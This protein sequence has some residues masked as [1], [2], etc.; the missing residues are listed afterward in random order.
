MLDMKESKSIFLLFVIILF[1][2]AP[3]SGTSQTVFSVKDRGHRKQSKIL[4]QV[5]RAS[6]LVHTSVIPVVDKIREVQE[7]TAKALTL[8]NGV[9]RNMKMVR[10]LIEIEGEIAELVEK[11]IAKLNEPRD[12]D[13]DGEDDLAFLDKWKHVKILLAILGQADNVFDLFKNV[14]EQD[15]TVMDDRGRLTLI[16]DAYH[17]ALKIRR[18]I[19]V[20]IRRINREIAGH[21]REK[22]EADM[23]A[24][25]FGAT[26]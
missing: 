3:F 16:K 24:K 10:R 1:F 13:G 2:I 14:V 20:Q 25:L 11:S 8:V 4:M 19:R 23:F 7:F 5:E 18:C 6:T 9:I 26:E 21:R 12:T 15:A 17:D 22:R